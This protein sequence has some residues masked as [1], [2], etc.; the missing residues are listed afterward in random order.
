M[1]RFNCNSDNEIDVKAGPGAGSKLADAAKLGIKV[2]GEE[3]F[4]EMLS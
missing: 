3:E 4:M 1:D 2:I